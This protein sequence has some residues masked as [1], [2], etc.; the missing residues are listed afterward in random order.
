MHQTLRQTLGAR[1]N[2]GKSL[3]YFA[4]TA[5][6]CAITTPA[7]AAEVKLNVKAAALVTP[8]SLWVVFTLAAIGIFLLS[9]PLFRKRS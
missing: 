9:L 8:A 3:F 4:F 2:I 6:S 5:V 1:T 7:Q